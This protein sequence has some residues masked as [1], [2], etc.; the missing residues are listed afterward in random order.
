LLVNRVFCELKTLKKRNLEDSSY[1]KRE[2][3]GMIWQFASTRKWLND[4]MRLSVGAAQSLNR[5]PKFTSDLR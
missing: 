2:N 1:L 4:R 3:R 5:S